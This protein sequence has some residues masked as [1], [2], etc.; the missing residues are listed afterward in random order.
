MRCEDCP[1]ATRLG[2]I[3]TGCVLR[4]GDRPCEDPDQVSQ[5][6]EEVRP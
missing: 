6:R 4:L 1:S 3:V 5:D 2:T